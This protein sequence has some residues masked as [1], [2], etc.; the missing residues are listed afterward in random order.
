LIKQR[1][2]LNEILKNLKWRKIFYKIAASFDVIAVIFDVRAII[3]DIR[4]VTA[5]R[6]C[7]VGNFT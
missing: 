7:Y 5:K 1:D 2:K 3:R 6:R 4:A